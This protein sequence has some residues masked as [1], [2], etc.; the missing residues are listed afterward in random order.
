[1]IRTLAYVF[2]IVVFSFGLVRASDM[3]DNELFVVKN[4]KSKFESFYKKGLNLGYYYYEELTN[5]MMPVFAGT[6]YGAGGAGCPGDKT[7]V[8]FH[9]FDCVTFVET[10]WALSFTLYEYQSN[11]VPKSTSPFKQFCKNL[12]QI[13]YFGG[14]NCGIDYRIHYF[15]QELEEL[16]RKG[17]A[18]NVAMANGFPFTKKINYITKN[19]DL[20]GDLSTSAQQK[21]VELV[22]NKT[23]RYFYPTKHRARYYPMA[24]DGDI[25]AFASTEPGLDVSHCGIITVED[26]EPKL[27]HA[28][29]LYGKVVIGQDLDRYLVGRSGKVNGFFVYRPQH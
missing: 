6:P 5:K 13:R 4:S 9:S 12:N 7:L 22:L 10:W 8:N 2:C 16:D 26:G 19:E 20:Y 11:H 27:N 15:T 18:F 1:M 14:E 24:K 29:Q 3:R 25:I 21:S 23:P 28:S 17:L